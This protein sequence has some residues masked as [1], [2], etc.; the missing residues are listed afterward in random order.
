[1]SSVQAPGNTPN[2]DCAICSGTIKDCVVTSCGHSYCESCIKAWL[3]KDNS[4]PGCRKVDPKPVPNHSARD[5]IEQIAKKTVVAAQQP[6]NSQAVP[7]ALAYV[8]V[9]IGFNPPVVVRDFVNRKG[10]TEQELP[11]KTFQYIRSVS[12]HQGIVRITTEK[13]PLAYRIPESAIQAYQ[14][15]KSD[16]AVHA[17]AAAVDA[18]MLHAL[19]QPNQLQIQVSAPKTYSRAEVDG[20]RRIMHANL[21]IALNDPNPVILDFLEFDSF[22]DPMMRQHVAVTQSRPREAVPITLALP[23]DQ[24]FELLSRSRT[25]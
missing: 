25:G 13:S 8:P 20:V 2:L 3:Q 1:M 23:A 19:C 24:Y 6:L 11:K 16:K 17:A 15:A 14:Q 9:T 18:I 7:E 21:C 12:F 5:I 4:C 22:N 10:F